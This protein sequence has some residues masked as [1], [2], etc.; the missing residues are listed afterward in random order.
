MTWLNRVLG[1]FFLLVAGVCGAQA[2]NCGTYPN[3]LTNGTTADANQVMADF[4]LIRNCANNNLAHN[5]ANSDITSLS[6]IT[7]PLSPAQ[8]GSS[9]FVGG[10]STGSA[11]AQVVAS[12][13]PNSFTLTQGNVVSFVAGFAN[14][15]ATTL[16]VF[17]LGAQTVNKVSAGALTALV[18]GDIL[19]GVQY[20]VTWDGTVFELLNPSTISGNVTGPGSAVSGNVASFNGTTGKII[21]DSGVAAAQVVT[22]AA[23][24]TNHAVVIGV[25]SQG[26]KTIAAGTT[27]Q[28]LKGVTGA[29]PAFGTA[30]GTLTAGTANTLNPLSTS[31]NNTQAHGLG[32]KPDI[33]NC[34]IENL[35]GEFGFSAGD[36]VSLFANN[37]GQ[38]ANQGFNV[39][40]DATN[41]YILTGTVNVVSVIRADTNALGVVTPGNWK[42]VCVPYKIN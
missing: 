34:Y 30:S 10:T 26:S 37:Q 31:A 29:D 20:Y 32:G 39:R 11:N 36:R 2:Q 24:L 9:L 33:V 28:V 23:N 35:T 18:T 19:V 13:S 7:T 3:I 21:Q 1:A 8:G 15:G 38:A 41:T 17:S 25:G 14:S 42:G 12:T 27:G 22:S 5:G 6:G 4:N 16:N 40:A